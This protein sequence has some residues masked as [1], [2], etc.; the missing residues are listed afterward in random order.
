MLPHSLLPI[1][2]QVLM[3]LLIVSI[4]KELHGILLTVL[5]EVRGSFVFCFGV[6]YVLWFSQVSHISSE[7]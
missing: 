3:Y 7:A 6:Y 5:S 4:L 1:H 2:W